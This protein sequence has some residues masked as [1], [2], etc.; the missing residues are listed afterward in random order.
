MHL[1]ALVAD[2]GVLVDRALRRVLLAAGVHVAGAYSPHE[3][4]IRHQQ[5]TPDLVVL[6]PGPSAPAAELTIREL[7][8]ARDTPVVLLADAAELSGLAEA[9]AMPG[10]SLRTTPCT[11]EEVLASLLAAAAAPPA[12]PRSSAPVE[13]GPAAPRHAGPFTWETAGD[14]VQLDGR[15]LVLTLRQHQ[16]LRLL[17]EHPGEVQDRADLV[18][19]AWGAAGRAELKALEAALPQ[20]RRALGR[21]AHLL[22]AVPRRGYLLDVDPDPHRAPGQVTASEQRAR[23]AGAARRVGPLLVG[24]LVLDP[25]RLEVHLHG[26][27]L[28]LPRREVQVLAVLAARQ[29]QYVDVRTL[30]QSVWPGQSVTTNT[31]GT[32]VRR[33]RQRLHGLDLTPPLTIDARNGRGYLLRQADATSSPS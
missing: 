14:F 11:P 17:L 13:S 18:G 2:R 6:S 4:I 27:L 8:R 7:R 12:A 9:L 33:L 3:L 21:H 15:P 29:G 24:A 23:S 16:L 5:D 19:Q 26:R 28:I 31:I 10:T 1:T 20:L 30:R 25:G 32:I 22:R